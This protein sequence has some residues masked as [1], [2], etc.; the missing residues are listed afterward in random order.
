M[1]FARCEENERRD[2]TIT[3]L[4]SEPDLAA[5]IRSTAMGERKNASNDGI[6]EMALA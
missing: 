1:F 2:R 5:S 3:M 4:H 6:S